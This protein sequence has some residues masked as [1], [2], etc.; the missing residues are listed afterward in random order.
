MP[1]PL[2]STAS[3]TCCDW[4]KVDTGRN[5]SVKLGDKLVSIDQNG[6]IIYLN[7]SCSGSM[8]SILIKKGENVVEGDVMGYIDACLHPALFNSMCV[9]CGD[10][11][12][13]PSPTASARNQRSKSAMANVRKYLLFFFYY[14]NSNV[15]ML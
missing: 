6:K 13:P 9:S 14:F 11:V 1:V 12:R 4:K 2:F 8:Q 5:K 7:A 15:F 10:T 3:G